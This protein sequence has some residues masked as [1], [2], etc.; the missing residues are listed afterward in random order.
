MNHR[1]IHFLIDLGVSKKVEEWLQEQGYNITA[2]RELNPKMTDKDILNLADSENRM[3]ITMDKG[4]GE[5]VY[6]SGLSH[7]GVL[8]LRLES[9]SGEEKVGI[10]TKILSEYSDELR[11]NF[12]V[13]QNGKLR[14]RK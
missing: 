13:F 9:A 3:V 6:G 11:N 5:L 4:F 12:C 10:I 1:K 14:I 7:S 8:L 2:V